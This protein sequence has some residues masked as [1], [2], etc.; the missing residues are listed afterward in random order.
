MTAYRFI[1]DYKD[2]FGVRWLLRRL[3][4]FPNAYYNYKK[5]RKAAYEEKKQYTKEQ[6]KAIYHEHNGVDGYRMMKASL[7]RKGI[8][9]SALTV[10]K[11]MNTELGLM[12]VTRRKLPE[13]RKGKPHKVFP[14]VLE[15]DFSCDEINTK[16]C[17]DFTY[18]FL[19]NRG[20]RYNCTILDLHDRSVIASIT[21][22]RITADL[23][24]RTLRK[25]I[26][27]QSKIKG[28]LILHSDYA[29]E[30]TMPKFFFVT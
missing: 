14:N 4:I 18:L 17:V 3:N 11:Y 20:K 6:I 19:E 30:K 1:D 28:V 15:Q 21:D 13:Y 12:S 10:H 8:V 26:E 22:R 29:E 2:Q 24:V 25:A 9:L 23:A 5:H 27:S 16:W 7:E